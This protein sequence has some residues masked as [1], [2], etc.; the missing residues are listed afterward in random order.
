MAIYVPS[1]VGETMSAISQFGSNVRANQALNMRKAQAQLNQLREL[2]VDMN[3]DQRYQRALGSLLSGGNT[4]AT[5]FGA[6]APVN[7]LSSSQQQTGPGGMRSFAPDAGKN[8]KLTDA[9][10]KEKGLMLQE[11][12]RT[13]EQDVNKLSDALMNVQTL[14][15]GTQVL[16]SKDGSITPVDQSSISEVEN[17]LGQ[18][19]Y[20]LQENLEELKKSDYWKTGKKN[21]AEGRYA[22]QDPNTGKWIGADKIGD[23]QIGS[24]IGK[25]QE[26][27][28]KVEKDL[29]KDK[30]VFMKQEADR[31]KN[32]AKTGGDFT[33]TETQMY[34]KARKDFKTLFDKAKTIE[35]KRKAYDDYVRDMHSIEDRYKRKRSYQP[36]FEQNFRSLY[37]TS[38]SGGRYKLPSGYGGTFNEVMFLNDKGKQVRIKVNAK[39]RE[40]AFRKLNSPEMRAK[41]GF[42]GS[43]GDILPADNKGR[44]QSGVIKQFFQNRELD[45]F[46]TQKERDTK[47]KNIQAFNRVSG[48]DLASGGSILPSVGF[49]DSK[50][51]ASIASRLGL[52][53][54]DPVVAKIRK[55]I[56]NQ[57]NQNL[58]STIRKKNPALAQQFIGKIIDLANAKGVAAANQFVAQ[59]SKKKVPPSVLENVPAKDREKKKQEY[60]LNYYARQIGTFGGQTGTMS[61]VERNLANKYTNKALRK[62]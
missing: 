27:I 49:S 6:S 21:I 28:K 7:Q 61:M 1:G 19:E 40:D 41:Y 10:R 2:G 22:Y 47:E 20:Q 54:G 51:K 36:P 26:T 23:K 5:L 31:I 3:T 16:A 37:R 60:L 8:K 17:K 11:A 9:Q 52:Q 59:I 29:A 15:D 35:E 62:R 43:R 18:K 13:G 48:G 4:L 12:I 25:E 32:A 50:L 24:I 45:Y 44:F 39:D 42:Q 14:P 56:D 46:K 30:Q 57:T 34:A 55:D 53:A 33:G 38:S 58:Y